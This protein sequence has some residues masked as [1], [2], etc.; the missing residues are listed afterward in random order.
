MLPVPGTSEQLYLTHILTLEFWDLPT[1]WFLCYD[2]RSRLCLLNLLFSLKHRV[3]THGFTNCAMYAPFVYSYSNTV[4]HPSLVA[5]ARMGHSLQLTSRP[6][7]RKGGGER[8][9]P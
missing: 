5:K 4:T 6:D 7:W 3:S 2:S 9:V 8:A 1:A